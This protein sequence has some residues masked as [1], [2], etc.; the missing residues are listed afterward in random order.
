VAG[1]KSTGKEPTPLDL[2]IARRIRERRIDIGMSQ[3]KLAAA[4]GVSFQQVQKYENGRNR[5]APGRLQPIC[6]ALAVRRDDL[7]EGFVDDEAAGGFAE[8]PAA[9]Y[10]PDDASVREGHALMEAFS[11]IK[12]PSVRQGVLSLVRSVADMRPASGRARKSRPSD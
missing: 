2:H 4:A 10:R 3:S 9:P 11:R 7:Y 8:A 6:D 12:D 1:S 5:I